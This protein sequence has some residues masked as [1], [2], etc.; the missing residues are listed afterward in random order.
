MVI[1]SGLIADKT[2]INNA[3]STVIEGTTPQRSSLVKS[4]SNAMQFAS[5]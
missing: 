4:H 3:K 5:L 2:K 1:L